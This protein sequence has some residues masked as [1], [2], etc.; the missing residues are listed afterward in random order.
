MVKYLIE[1]MPLL[2]MQ[3]LEQENVLKNKLH[4]L[5]KTDPGLQELLE[6]SPELKIP[7]VPRA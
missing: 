7:E 1:K 6:R 4:D 5:A 3:N 2:N